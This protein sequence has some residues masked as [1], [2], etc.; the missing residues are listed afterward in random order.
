MEELW[1][2]WKIT[3]PRV[4]VLFEVLHILFRD[5]LGL[6]DQGMNLV[7]KKIDL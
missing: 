7:N 4:Q 3:A 6:V 5:C 2:L 1:S